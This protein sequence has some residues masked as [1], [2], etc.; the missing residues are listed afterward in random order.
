M[1]PE[2]SKSVKAFKTFE[3]YRDENDDDPRSAAGEIAIQQMIQT[4]GWAPD[5]TAEITTATIMQV[6]NQQKNG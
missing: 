5:I 6:N 2:Y 1:S 4:G 3:Q